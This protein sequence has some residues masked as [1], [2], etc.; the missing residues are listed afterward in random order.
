MRCPRVRETVL[1]SLHEPEMARS[2]GLATRL[3]KLLLY[4]HDHELDGG[5]CGQVD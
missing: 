4:P 5:V 2:D 1:P 3:L